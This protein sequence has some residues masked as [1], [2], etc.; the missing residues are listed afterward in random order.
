MTT[1][2][3]KKYDEL[4]KQDEKDGTSLSTAFAKK[5]RDKDLS[6]IKKPKLPIDELEEVQKENELNYYGGRS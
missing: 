3:F 6:S 1:N 5:M 2:W 4:Y